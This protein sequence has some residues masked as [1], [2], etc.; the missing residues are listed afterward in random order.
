MRNS[1]TT[2]GAH[3]MRQLIELHDR[4]ITFPIFVPSQHLIH[5]IVAELFS[6]NRDVS[7]LDEAY[8]IDELSR[9]SDL[10]PKILIAFGFDLP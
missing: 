6:S 2:S 3:N 10:G 4:L 8:H 7:H 1:F 5:R 9:G